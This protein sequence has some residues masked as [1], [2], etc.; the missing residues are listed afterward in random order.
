MS[1]RGPRNAWENKEKYD[2]LKTDDRAKFIYEYLKTMPVTSENA[3]FLKLGN[4]YD[5]LKYTIDD[6][7]KTGTLNSTTWYARKI[8]ERVVELYPDDVT[9]S[10]EHLSHRPYHLKWIGP[11]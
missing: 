11:I 7:L 2:R 3:R 9:L 1:S 10:H 5:L 8:A 4:V 6:D